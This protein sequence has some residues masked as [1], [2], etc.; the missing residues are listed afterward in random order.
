ME[1]AYFLFFLHLSLKGYCEANHQTNKSDL[2]KHYK[3]AEG[4]NFT[5]PYCNCSKMVDMKST[6]SSAE[7]GGNEEQFLD[8][9]KLFIAE[10]KHSGNYSCFTNGNKLFF[11]LQVEKMR[12]LWRNESIKILVVCAG[13]QISCPGFGCS[14]NTNVTWYKNKKKV[15]DQHRPSREV[16]E[17]LYL[18]PVHEKDDGVFFCHTQIIEGGVTWTLRTGVEVIV[19]PPPSRS[20]PRIP[21]DNE[22]KEV[23]IGQPYT[24]LCKALFPFELNFSP[25][26]EW[27]MNND[28]NMTLLDSKQKSLKKYTQEYEVI[29]VATINEVTPHH[30][31]YTYTCIA[32]NTF[33]NISAT[34]KLKRKIKVQWPSLVG[35]LV[36]AFLPVGGLIIVVRVKWLEIQLIYRCYFK[37]GKHNGDEKEFDVFLSYVW[38]PASEEVLGGEIISSRSPLNDEEGELCITDLLNEEVKAT[39]KPLEVLLPQVLED[40]WGYRLCLL[41]RDVIPGG[42]YTNDVVLAIKKSQMLICVLSDDYFTNSNAVFELESGVQ[43]DPP[44]PTLVQRALGVLPSLDWRSGEPSHSNFWRSLR[45]TMPKNKVKLVSVR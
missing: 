24:F 18:E 36:T 28:G 45:K 22:P 19:I 31:T 41:E 40:Q 30:L 6:S 42:A 25:K 34:I 39:K 26:I 5:M 7:G 2:Q 11:R 43:P 4:Q 20:P 8:C 1:T 38:S 14:N 23:E 44:L 3:A 16:R 35:Y 29:Q 12:C 10:A 27:Y 21:V 37:N 9:G 17:V 33:G 32:S 15:S 13:G